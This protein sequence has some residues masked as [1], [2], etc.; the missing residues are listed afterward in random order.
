[1][2]LE[3]LPVQPLRMQ[4]CL[5]VVTGCMTVEGHLS[6]WAFVAVAEVLSVL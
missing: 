2:L 5:Q 6:L 4:T 3:K 1:M